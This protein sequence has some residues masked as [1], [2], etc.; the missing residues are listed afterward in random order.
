[1]NE[2]QKI[3][4][5]N[6][7]PRWVAG[8]EDPTGPQCPL[9]P[10]PRTQG[11]LFVGL[12]RVEGNEWDSKKHDEWDSKKNNERECNTIAAESK[13]PMSGWYKRAN[14]APGPWAQNTGNLTC[15]VKQGKEQWIRQ[16]KE[17]WMRQQKEQ[18]MKT[19]EWGEWERK[20]SMSG[21]Y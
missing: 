19:Q 6:A 5:E 21:W 16:Q 2:T 20:S 11:N 8:I 14:W 10:G 1:M 7:D 3:E 18:S 9:G 4:N 13:S 12:N 17:Q 15:C